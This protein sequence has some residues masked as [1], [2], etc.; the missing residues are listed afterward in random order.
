MN[1][2]SEMFNFL[3]KLKENNNREW[4]NDNKKEFEGVRDVFIEFLSY[5]IGKIET[6][7][8]HI[9]G[10][11]PKKSMYRI[12][13]DTRFS[14]DKTPYKTH[15]GGYICAGGRASGNPGYYVHI[16]PGGNS[17]IGG[18]LYHPM[19]DVLA[20]VRQEIDYNGDA[21]MNV[22][23]K[24]SFK[25]RFDI[26]SDDK[27]KRPPKGYEADNPHIEWL[28]MKSFLV[29]QS[30]SDKDVIGNEYTNGVVSGFKEMAPFIE[31][32]REGMS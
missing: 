9:L 10:V 18:G 13:R 17:I 27:L 29:M 30:F 2:F 14:K 4:F 6:F 16:E 1:D 25:K 7:D 24:A 15:F 22:L 20:K 11:D 21:L 28:K 31:F 26:Y 5:L 32:L 19:P 3:T 12:Y 8:K 23:N